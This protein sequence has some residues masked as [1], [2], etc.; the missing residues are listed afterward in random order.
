[1]PYVNVFYEH[2]S[3]FLFAILFC[4]RTGRKRRRVRGLRIMARRYL[5]ENSFPFNFWASEFR[6]FLLSIIRERNAAWDG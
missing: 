2:F 6:E 5:S 3:V 1:M 4:S